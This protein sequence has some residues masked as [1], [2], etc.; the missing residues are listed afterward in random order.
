ML[1]PLEDRER[2]VQLA[3]EGLGATG[4]FVADQAVLSLYAAG[5]TSGLVVE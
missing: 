3:F 5:R 4:V 2:L 1:T